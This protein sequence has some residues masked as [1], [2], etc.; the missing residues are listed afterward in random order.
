MNEKEK[1][2]IL[3]QIALERYESNRLKSLMI[4]KI[5]ENWYWFSL[6]IILLVWVI[7]DKNINIQ[8]LLKFL[9]IAMIG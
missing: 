3:H 2:T 8:N 7:D 5:K 9:K 1:K 4:K 6:F